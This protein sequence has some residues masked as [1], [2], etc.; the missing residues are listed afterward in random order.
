MTTDYNPQIATQTRSRPWVRHG[1]MGLGV[2]IVLIGSLW[3]YL[4]SGRYISTDNAYLKADKILLAPDVSGTVVSVSVHDNEAVKK[5]QELFRIDPTPYQIAYNKA[6]ADLN[7]TLI[8]INEIK[9]QYR[10]KKAELGSAEVEAKFADRELKRQLALSAKGSASVSQRDN[11]SLRRDTAEKQVQKLQGEVAEMLASL[12]NNPDIKP[13]DHPLY[14]AAQAALSKAE[15]DLS[16]TKMVAP[17]DGIIGNAPSVGDYARA[18]MPMV[19][20]I[21]N[22]SYWI[23]ANFKETELTHVIPGQTV[24][25]HVDTYP[26]ASWTGKVQSISPATGSEFSVLPAQNST[27]NWVKVV[28]RIATRISVDKGPADMPLRAGMSTEVEIDTGRYPHLSIFGS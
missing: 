4:T 12:N 1:L 20:F 18:S 10:Q 24:S 27:G 13:E 21:A 17:A 19:N 11:A 22:G 28:Q 2:V 6:Q 15:L 8:R 5:G 26:G 23:E 9:A 16:R 3:A 25:I 14:I 7:S